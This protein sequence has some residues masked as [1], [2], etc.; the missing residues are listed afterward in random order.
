[1]KKEARTNDLVGRVAKVVNACAV[2]TTG[3]GEEDSGG[4]E[5]VLQAGR[6][7]EEDYEV[8]LAVR[9]D[10]SE[11]IEE[12][13]LYGGTMSG[14]SRAVTD[15][16]TRVYLEHGIHNFRGDAT[17]YKSVRARAGR[18]AKKLIARAR[19]EVAYTDVEQRFMRACERF[20]FY[21]DTQQLIVNAVAQVG[22]CGSEL[23]PEPRLITREGFRAAQNWVLEYSDPTI[24]DRV[25]GNLRVKYTDDSEYHA[26]V[27]RLKKARKKEMRKAEPPIIK[28]LRQSLRGVQTKTVNMMLT[29]LFSHQVAAPTNAYFRATAI[30]DEDEEGRLILLDFVDY[31]TVNRPRSKKH[32]KLALRIPEFQ[33]NTIIV[34]EKFYKDIIKSIE[35]RS[36]WED[37]PVLIVELKGTLIQPTSGM[38][39]LIA[40]ML[41]AK[42]QRPVLVYHVASKGGRKRGRRAV[43]G[44]SG[45]LPDKGSVA[46]D[47]LFYRERMK[48]SNPKVV[49]VTNSGGHDAA[50]GMGAEVMPDEDGGVLRSL[51]KVFFP[52]LGLYEPERGNKGLV[53]VRDAIDARARHL[54]NHGFTDVRRYLPRVNQF[55][56]ARRMAEVSTATLD[57][58]GP[59]MKNLILEFRDVRVLGISKAKKNDGTPYR[60]LVVEDEYGFTQEFRLFDEEVDLAGVRVGGVI[61]FR[62]EPRLRKYMKPA[63]L[64]LH[65]KRWTDPGR[66]GHPEKVVGRHATGPS[67]EPVLHVAAIVERPDSIGYLLGHLNSY[68]NLIFPCDT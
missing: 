16:I 47:Q 44:V 1:M 15:A 40:G 53:V 43:V 67:Y 56:I 52:T 17:S 21:D 49:K 4:V 11:Y 18:D 6:G 46:L 13:M 54:A 31:Y 41:A 62:A 57:P 36:G 68:S 23:E 9:V 12:A 48:P 60:I 26:A 45:R 28:V 66:A 51:Q 37:D 20:G 55:R 7:E 30:E 27:Q 63:S 35:S 29:R 32:R 24:S 39:G 3:E 25:L 42:Y 34:R 2:M 19:E 8:G 61:S 33:D 10:L 14:F 22:D 50:A 5:F 58:F 38:R 59:D 64:M 65:Q